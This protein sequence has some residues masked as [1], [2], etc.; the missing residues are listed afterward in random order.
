M[1]F[2]SSCMFARKDWL[3]RTLVLT[4]YVE[5][6]SILIVAL[7]IPY[8]YAWSVGVGIVFLSVWL[9]HLISR[10]TKDWLKETVILILLVK[11][12]SIVV[13]LFLYFPYS[14]PIV[15]AIVVFIVWLHIRSKH[16]NTLDV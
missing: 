8:Q 14:L 1:V 5:V 4:I 2:S 10:T 16:A 11:G 3:K 7:F 6:V 9:I 15:S 12:V 13:N